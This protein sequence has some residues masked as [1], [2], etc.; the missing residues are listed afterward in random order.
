M[1]GFIGGTKGGEFISWCASTLTW[2]L[3]TA[4]QRFLVLNFY[5]KISKWSPKHVHS[6]PL[7]YIHWVRPQLFASFPGHLQCDRNLHGLE[8]RPSIPVHLCSLVPRLI[9]SSCVSLDLRLVS[10]CPFTYSSSSSSGLYFLLTV[11]LLCTWHLGGRKSTS[12]QTYGHCN[13]LC[14][15]IEMNTHYFPMSLSVC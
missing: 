11:L 8:I 14:S 6:Y 1:H 15:S 3:P 13:Q 7:K 12:S 5:P 2:I 9:S 10:M 4:P